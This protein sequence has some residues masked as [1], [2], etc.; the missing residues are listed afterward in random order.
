MTPLAPG[1]RRV[2]DFLHDFHTS[3][4]YMPT[5]AEIAQGLG[6]KSANAADEHLQALVRLGMI[7]RQPGRGRSIRLTA[8]A[9]QLLNVDAAADQ[10]QMI[11]LP[12][13]D[14]AKVNR[15]GEPR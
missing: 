14:M 6:W 11:A 3:N 10:P 13:V 1:R 9:L 12:V 4:G 2:L 7:T 15:I 5:S 8:A